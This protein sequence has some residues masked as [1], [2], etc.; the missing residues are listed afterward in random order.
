MKYV[1]HRPPRRLSLPGSF[2]AGR[3]VTVSSTGHAPASPLGRPHPVGTVSTNVVPS[4]I[5]VLFRDHWPIARRSR[6]LPAPLLDGNQGRWPL[7]VSSSSVSYMTSKWPLLTCKTDNVL[8]TYFYF[9][10]IIGLELPVWLRLFYCIYLFIFIWA[11][12]LT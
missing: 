3:Q 12:L 1:I 8:L 2:T 6:P 7:W 11:N 9:Y 10:I 5:T 4:A